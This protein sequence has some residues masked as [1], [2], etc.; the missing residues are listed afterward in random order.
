MTESGTTA[1]LAHL[2]V[3]DLTGP[4]SQLCARIFADFG[5]EVIKIE[6][7]DG[8]AA[9]RQGPFPGDTPDPEQSFSFVLFNRGKKSVALDMSIAADRHAL[10][11]LAA[12][13]DVLVEDAAPGHWHALGLGY[14]DLRAA[15]PGLVYVSITP[16]G[17]T[18]PFKGYK[19]GELVAEATGGLLFANGDDALRPAYAPYN[20][21][22]QIAC[23]HAAYGALAALRARNRTG[24]GQHV[25]VSRQEVVLYCQGNYIPRYSRLNEIARRERA[26]STAGVNT[27]RTRDRGYVNLAPFN[28][29]H[30]QRLARDVMKH[31]EL[32]KDEWTNNTARRNKLRIAEA[33]RLIGEYCATVDRDWLVETCQKAGLPAVAVLTPESFVDHP[34]T[35]VRGFMQTVSQPGLGHYRTAGPPAILNATPWRADRPAP[36]LGQHTA[37]VLAELKARSAEVLERRIPAGAS[38][39]AP[40]MALEGIRVADFTRAF[41]GPIATMLL[42]FLGA[43][44][45]KVES[46]DLDDSRNPA[47]PTFVELNRAKLSCLIDTRAPEGKDLAKRLVRESGIVVENFRPGVMDRLG[48][49]YDDLRKVRPDVIML[50]MPGFGNSGPLR[51]YYSYGQQVMGMTGLL[52]IWGHAE[53]PVE[54]R[55]KYAF[56]DYVAGVLGSLSLLVA[57][58]HRDRTGEG[59][60]IELSQVEA[61]AHLM[62]LAYVEYTELGRTLAPHGNLSTE[63]AP[64]DLYP[65]LGFDAWCAI[66]VHTE[67]QWQALVKLMGS[68]EWTRGP[69]FGSLAARVENKAALDKHLADWSVRFTP[70]Q[71]TK[72]LQEAGIPSGIVATAEDLYYDPHLRA[73]GMIVGIDHSGDG[74]AEH[75]GMNIHL[76]DTPGRADLPAPAKG[77]H[78]QDIYTRVLGL[79]PE[80]QSRLQAAGALR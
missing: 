76:S 14:D 40:H 18:G 62:S 11:A 22:C 36:R 74:F 59:Q 37:E 20:L 24:R 33:D 69:K 38:N 8:D 68:P 63:A 71:L 52:H 9:R 12:S 45:I 67:E 75:A 51:D 56:P 29:Q 5:A 10:I 2:R 79:S 6:P 42:G 57:L 16:F 73:R 64:H 41:A 61:L 49:G 35:Q 39:G 13:V 55:V 34:Q 44:V 60:Y 66:E 77:Q 17:Q 48:L 70:R 1:A 15:N 53:S 78:S 4:L 23:I 26:G 47:Q 43:E 7:P 25:D 30:F 19:G 31:P 3:L 46:A 21:L 50:A 27:Y 58:E 32:S 28:A 80:E 54:A 72:M 65:C